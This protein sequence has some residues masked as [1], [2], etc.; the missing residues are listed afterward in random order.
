M[1]GGRCGLYPGIDRLHNSPEYKKRQKQAGWQ[2]KIRVERDRQDEKWGFP[3]LNTWCEWAS[4]LAEEA[5]ELARELNELNFGGG[6]M[7][8]MAAEA[9]QVAAVALAIL[10][11]QE[12]AKEFTEKVMAARAEMEKEAQP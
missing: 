10:E 1:S 9:V 5:G 8:R 6:N 11:Q 4:I 2:H 7:E 3:Q 12:I